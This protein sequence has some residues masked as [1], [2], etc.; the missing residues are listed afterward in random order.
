MIEKL[1][2]NALCGILVVL[3]SFTVLDSPLNNY[4]FLSDLE[5][6]SDLPYEH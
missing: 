2:K 1:V 6:N 5:I 4:F 3:I